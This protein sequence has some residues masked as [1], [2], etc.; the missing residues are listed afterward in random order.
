M[1]SVY[2]NKIKRILPRINESL[3]EDWISNKARFIYDSFDLQRIS[4]PL[5][6]LGFL[7][8]Q[9]FSL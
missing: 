7:F 2:G 8:S 5:L 4:F 6:N 9:N 1:L 3:N